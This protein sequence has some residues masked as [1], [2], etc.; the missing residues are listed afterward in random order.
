MVS[1]IPSPGAIVVWEI[2][3]TA[4][5]SA[6]AMKQKSPTHD[7]ARAAKRRELRDVEIMRKLPVA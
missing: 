5:G 2:V 6:F 7:S 3:A 1:V 4:L